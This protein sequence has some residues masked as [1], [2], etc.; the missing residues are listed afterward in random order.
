M[1]FINKYLNKLNLSKN[2]LSL[3][4]GLW[5]FI[6][7]L[8]IFSFLGPNYF[9][10]NSPKGFVVKQGDTFS[11][12]VDNLCKEKIIGNST[13]MNIVAFL[14]GAETKVKAGTYKIE[15]G[16]NYFQLID[17]F[18]KGTPGN[19]IKVTIPE[20]I[21]QHNLAELLEDKL[22]ISAKRFLELSNDK[23]FLNSLRIVS[24]NLEGYLLPNTYYFFKNSSEKDIIK[25]LK[26]EMDKIFNDKAVINQ[27][28]K[29]NMSKNEILTLASIID[30]ETNK[31][32]ELKTIS[33]VYHNR[34][35]R[36]MLLQADPT[37]QY[38]KRN[39]RSKNKVYY[40]DLEIDSPYNT[41]KYKG[42]P[43]SPINN[44][45]KNAVLA[46][47]FPKKTDYIFF[48]ADGTGGHKFAR[49]LSVHNRNVR[50]YRRWRSSQ[51][52]KWQSIL[53]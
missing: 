2:E 26:I 7:S 36:G 6:V 21:W 40:K 34:L 35:K 51:W 22:N 11:K 23:S 5:S 45:G 31:Q 49:K 47:I 15:N 18:V 4:I 42:L 38:L 28:A 53:L 48:V 33:G 3:I 10:G 25:K 13:N 8:L 9:E 50:A 37:I 30:G 41:Y 24:N 1:N 52:E 14:Y 16:L 46:A 44:P 12:V 29:L 27:M 19:Q 32:S 17:L 43:P 20:G 39:R